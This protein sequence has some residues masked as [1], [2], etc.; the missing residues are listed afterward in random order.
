MV[1]MAGEINT[2]LG[3]NDITTQLSIVPLDEV[4]DH[5]DYCEEQGHRDPN[6]PRFWGSNATFVE[7]DYRRGFC[8]AL[9]LHL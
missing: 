4:A 3:D 6:R 1:I 2:D 9:G 7:I 5:P 8:W